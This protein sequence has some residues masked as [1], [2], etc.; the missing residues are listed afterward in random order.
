MIEIPAQ[1]C[2][3]FV[4][5]CERATEYHFAPLVQQIEALKARLP[6]GRLEAGEVAVTRHSNLNEIHAVFHL[7]APDRLVTVSEVRSRLDYLPFADVPAGRRTPSLQTL[8]FSRV[9]E[10]WCSLSFEVS[11]SPLT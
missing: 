1:R 2:K 7:A 3:D 5:Q 9:S 8:P 10:L 6:N 11:L 4:A